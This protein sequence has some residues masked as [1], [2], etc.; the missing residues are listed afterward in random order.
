MNKNGKTAERAA[1]IP[2]YREEKHLAVMEI[3]SM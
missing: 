3:I 1:C 2:Q